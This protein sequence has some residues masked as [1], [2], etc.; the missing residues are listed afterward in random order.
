MKENKSV[1][2]ITLD[3][4]QEKLMVEMIEDVKSAPTTL[5]ELVRYQ[6]HTKRIYRAGYAARDADFQ[7]LKECADKMA[8]DI[9]RCSGSCEWEFAKDYRQT[10]KQMG[11]E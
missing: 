8:N 2:D 7:K 4:E 10:L 1:D 11:V 5:R 3:A 6:K 9:G